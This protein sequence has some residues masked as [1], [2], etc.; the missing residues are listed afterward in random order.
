MDH[1]RQGLSRGNRAGTPYRRTNRRDRRRDPYNR[2]GMVHA[3]DSIL[4]HSGQRL[5]ALPWRLSLIWLPSGAYLVGI[6]IRLPTIHAHLLDASQSSESRVVDPKVLL[7]FWVCHATLPIGLI[8]SIFD[9]AARN[10]SD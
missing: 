3:N 4:A 10:C 5:C 7:I 8:G 2:T 9:C 6:G 1:P